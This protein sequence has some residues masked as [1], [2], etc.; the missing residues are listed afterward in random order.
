MAEGENKSTPA[1]GTARSRAKNTPAAKNTAAKATA[2]TSRTP[3]KTT[4]ANA[5]PAEPVEVAASEETAVEASTEKETSAVDTPETPDTDA[6]PEKATATKSAKSTP[7]EAAPAKAGK[8][9]PAKAA[10]STPAKSGPAKRA[11]AKG[12]PARGTSRSTPSKS[13][14]GGGKGGRRTTPVVVNRSLPW[15]MIAATAAVVIFAVAVIGYAVIKVER[16][17]P[18]DPAK[19]IADAAKIPGIFHEPIAAR[20]HTTDA[21]KYDRNPPIGGNHDANW[22]DCS[23]TVYAQPLRNENAVHTLEHGAVW[24]AYRPDLGAGDVD[25]LKSV[26]DGKNY[27]LMSPYPGLKS[28]VSLQAWG[29]QLAL[30]SVNMD[31]VN[32]FLRDLRDNGNNAPE[33]HG[34][35][36]NP[37]FKAA[38]LTPGPSATATPS[39]SAS[40]STKPSGSST[41]TPTKP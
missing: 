27:T 5:A 29:Y 36:A 28:A 24:I 6:A 18:V 25:K 2:R 7:A 40:V 16:S 12:T 1:K 13:R 38:P 22:A 33:P 32:R 3:A 21:V 4:P 41:A 23:G 20:E 14:P 31:L 11:P 34:V 15:G 26:V 39:P 37:D 19:G 9:T 8:S 30:D 10:K 35:C 17:K